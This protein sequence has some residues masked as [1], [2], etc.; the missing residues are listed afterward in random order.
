MFSDWA[1]VL[2]ICLPVP[3]ESI[4]RSPVPERKPSS[5]RSTSSVMLTVKTPSVRIVPSPANPATV[6]EKPAKS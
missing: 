3:A 6:S 4:T 1:E 2:R 5:R